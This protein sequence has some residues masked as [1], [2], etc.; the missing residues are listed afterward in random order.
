MFSVLKR[1]SF[2]VNASAYSHNEVFWI[3]GFCQTQTSARGGQWG[4]CVSVVCALW[5]GGKKNTNGFK[6][7]MEGRANN[8][9]FCLGRSGIHLLTLNGNIR[10][11]SLIAAY[12]WLRLQLLDCTKTGMGTTWCDQL[13]PATFLKLFWV[14]EAWKKKFNK[15]IKP[16]CK[17]VSPRELAYEKKKLPNGKMRPLGNTSYII[18][19]LS[20]SAS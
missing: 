13:Q 15:F 20:F 4:Q 11:T 3:S 16:H 17:R 1:N 12:R 2:P 14:Q 6:C 7:V 8:V 18:L 10:L 19:I 9:A 5:R